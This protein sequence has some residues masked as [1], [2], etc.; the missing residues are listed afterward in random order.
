VARDSTMWGSATQQWAGAF[1]AAFDDEAFCRVRFNDSEAFIPAGSLVMMYHCLHLGDD[2][3]FTVLVET[4]H[5]RWMIGQLKPGSIF[6]DVGSSIGEM[7]IPV[8]LQ[9]HDVSI[10]AFEPAKRARRLLLATL[11]RNEITSVRVMPAAISNRTGVIPFL[12]RD[13]DPSLACPWLPE[14]SAI[15]QPAADT[16]A[17]ARIHEV[18]ALTLDEFARRNGIRGRHLVVKIDIEGFEIEALEGAQ[19]F[20][21]ENVVDLAIDI[22]KRPGGEELTEAGCRELLSPHGYRFE[23][24]GHVLLCKSG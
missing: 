12:E 14:A 1:L 16:P 18:A 5:L 22:H 15:A 19:D 17:G 10:Y 23:N 11:R 4:E 3:R 24:M 21:R 8:A 7:T 20:L 13:I 2:S 9:R 6:L